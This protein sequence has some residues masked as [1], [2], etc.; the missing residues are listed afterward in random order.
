MQSAR[1]GHLRGLLA[2]VLCGLVLCTSLV[3]V[4]A[5]C[6]SLHGWVFGHPHAPE[7]DA[8]FG[9]FASLVEHMQANAA[10][11]G[12]EF[13]LFDSGD[14]IEGTGLSDATDVH[15]EYIFPVVQMVNG[16]TG[17]TMGNHDI[18]HDNVIELMQR[19]FIPHF[20]ATYLTDNSLIK[21]TGKMIGGPFYSFRTALGMNCLVMGYMFNFTQPAPMAEVTPVSQSLLEAYFKQAMQIKNVD[22]IVVVAHIDPTTPPEL[23]QIYAALRK[24]QPT[25]PLVLL[26][27]HRHITYFSWLDPNAFTMES[28]KYFEVVGH[29]TFDIDQDHQITQFQQEWVN[30]SRS[31]FYSLAK[32]NAGNF[33]TERGRKTKNFIYSA[34][35]K[36]QLNVTLGCSPVTLSPDASYTSSDSLYHFYVNNIVPAVVFNTSLGRTSFFITNDGAL[37]YEL[38]E[39]RVSMNDVYTV[40]PFKDTF[41]YFLLTG[42]QLRQTLAFLT[43]N[44]QL[45]NTGRVPYVSRLRDHHRKRDISDRFF[46]S[47]IAVESNQVYAVVLAEYDS[48]TLAM[49]LRQL[50]PAGKWAA[51]PYPT[52]FSSTSALRAFVQAQWPCRPSCPCA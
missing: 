20:N 21:Q 37:R 32:K 13:F 29:V 34:F 14:L 7:L 24:A 40:L 42:D 11:A 3:V 30:T 5:T 43:K 6:T 39:G 2:W 49:V 31:N 45:L 47:D 51:S 27:G 4:P 19:S 22:M 50:F 1:Q 15:G 8:D 9:D 35:D 17:L 46:F 25:V 16:Y 33:L 52:A 41:Y 10:A 18:G 26:S 48:V 44:K 28:G 38:Y 12:E 23:S 36:L